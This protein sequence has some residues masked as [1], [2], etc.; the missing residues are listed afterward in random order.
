MVRL[1]RYDWWRDL[2]KENSLM[3]LT[4]IARS[5]LPDGQFEIIGTRPGEK[6]HEQMIGL[7]DSPYTI[8]YPDHYKIF[9]AINNWSSDPKRNFGGNWL[10]LILSTDQIQMKNGCLLKTYLNGLNKIV[11][12]RIYLS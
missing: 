1:R 6:L 11:I 5:I 3:K 8:E 10:P 4:D 7:E 12:N 2:C 9:P